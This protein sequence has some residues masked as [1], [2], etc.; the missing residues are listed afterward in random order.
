MSSHTD[1]VR[2]AYRTEGGQPVGPLLEQQPGGLWGLP[3]RPQLEATD[4]QRILDA[5]RDRRTL[6]AIDSALL[7]RILEING[8]VPTI[9]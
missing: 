7:W 4:R 9:I 3:A 6:D 1:N 2:R 5:F 8:Q